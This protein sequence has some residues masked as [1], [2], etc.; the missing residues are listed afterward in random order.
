MLQLGITIELLDSEG[1]E[2]WVRARSYD[3]PR[4]LHLG[5][6]MEDVH[7]TITNAIRIV[8][9]K[10]E[11]RAAELVAKMEAERT[12]AEEKHHESEEAYIAAQPPE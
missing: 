2:K 7:D 3:C 1:K 5:R 6:L 8:T 12:S 10:Q 9:R 4:G 11:L